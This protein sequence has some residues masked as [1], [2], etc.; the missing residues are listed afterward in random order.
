MTYGIISTLGI[1][2]L[3]GFGT[4]LVGMGVLALIGRVFDVEG[5]K[6]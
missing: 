5:E 6:K 3:L 1:M 2:A 4:F